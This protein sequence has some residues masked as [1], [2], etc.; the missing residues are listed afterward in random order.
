VR[1]I[2]SAFSVVETLFALMIF[3]A[4]MGILVAAVIQSKVIFQATDIN[5]TLAA[6]SRQIL[7]RISSELINS[8]RAQV[9]ITE[10]SPVAGTDKISFHLPKYAFGVPVLT[11]AGSI[12]WD[13]D[14]ISINLSPTVA[15]QLVRTSNSGSV[16]IGNGVN[17]ISF[18]DHGLD[19]ALYLDEIRMVLNLRKSDTDT[20]AYNMST[21]SVIKLRN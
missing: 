20:R 4:L 10:N 18:F 1:K 16:V 11:A 2:N 15:G 8:N 7:D 12:D 14:V 17:N 19:S 9:T 21:S 3:L 13:P 6:E 5:T